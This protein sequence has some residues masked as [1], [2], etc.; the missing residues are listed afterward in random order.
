[1]QHD[2]VHAIAGDYA[3]TE[4]VVEPF[5]GGANSSFALHTRQGHYVLTVFDEK[6]WE[7]VIK[8]GRLLELLAVHEF[9]T[10]RLLQ[11]K[12]G[13]LA[14]MFRD[15]PVMVKEYID[16]RV[17]KDLDTTMVSQLGVAMAKL[18]TVPTPDYLPDEHAY[19][20]QMFSRAIGR[21]INPEYETWLSGQLAHLERS[22]PSQLPRGL[23]HADMFYDNVLF[24]GTDLKAVIDFE[25]ACCYYRVFDVGMGI[26]GLCADG[27]AIDLDRARAMVG[28]YRQVRRMEDGEKEALQLFV[29]YAATA[30]SYWRFWKYQI[31][32]PTPEKA[33]RYREMVRLAQDARAIPK[34]KFI[35][36]VFS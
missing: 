21:N 4:V 29:E 9:P 13:G 11:T 32:A 22:I 24:D 7:D 23:I 25:E 36:A 28:G 20:L 30:T 3:L 19:G 5:E 27:A 8:I 34:A 17:I 31:D 26:V 18:H 33:D 14:T 15:K 6:S 35:D 2:D 12:E 1:M 10:T 16:G